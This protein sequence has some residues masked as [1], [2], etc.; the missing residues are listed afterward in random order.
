S[1]ESDES[2]YLLG[3]SSVEM[4]ASK[5]AK[6]APVRLCI[7]ALIAS[8]AMYKKMAR[9]EMII[10]EM[11][12]DV[13]I[14]PLTGVMNRAGWDNSLARLESAA[15]NQVTAVIVLDMDLLKHVNDTQGHGAGDALLQKTAQTLSGVLR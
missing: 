4:P 11:K 13:F 3:L 14:D 1:T 7:K 6:L 12:R 15:A 10:Q 5:L 9:S 8:L 2:Y